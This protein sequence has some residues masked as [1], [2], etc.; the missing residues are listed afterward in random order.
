MKSLTK[1]DLTE[2]IYLCVGSHAN[3][4]WWLNE[5]DF[6]PTSIQAVSEDLNALCFSSSPFEDELEC[7]VIFPKGNKINIPLQTKPQNKIILVVLS[8]YD[9]LV[10][11][12]GADAYKKYASKTVRQIDWDNIES[13]K[14]IEYNRNPETNKFL[15]QTSSPSMFQWMKKSG[16]FNY[17]SFEP[18]EREVTRLFNLLGTHKAISEYR[19]MSRAAIYSVFLTPDRT[20]CSFYT[21]LVKGYGKG[22]FGVCPELWIYL[23][24]YLQ[25]YA[26]QYRF[27]PDLL[28][29]KFATWVYYCNTKWATWD[30]PGL[31]SYIDKRSTKKVYTFKTKKLW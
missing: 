16:D 26:D 27:R 12:A 6:K 8:N 11:K 10:E 23:D 4:W 29:S 15:N 30:Y 24:S 28:L 3:M 31:T 9:G 2:G 7:V 20:K 13:W 17:H 25:T 14:D 18:N 5:L 21:L 1:L 19:N 22:N